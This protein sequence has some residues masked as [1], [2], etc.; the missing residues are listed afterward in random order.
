MQ[1]KLFKIRLEKEMME[2]KQVMERGLAVMQWWEWIV[3]PG[4]RRLAIQRSKELN[5]LKRSRMNCFYTKELQAGSLSRLAQLRQVQTEIQEWYEA[6]KLFSNQGLMMSSSQR[7]F[8]SSIMN[9]MSST[10][11]SLQS[12]S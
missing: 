5:Q 6:E 1:D 8:E 11:R 10:A 7:K 4:I 12:S 2:W 9:N 3:K